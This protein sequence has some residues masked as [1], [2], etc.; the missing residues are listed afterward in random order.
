M[1]PICL[2]ILK[3]IVEPD[4]FSLTKGCWLLKKLNNAVTV[5]K[6]AHQSLVTLFQKPNPFD[7]G[8][9]YTASFLRA[10]WEVEK[11]AQGTKDVIAQD[12]R[13]ELARLISLEDDLR[14][15]W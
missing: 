10:Q 2:S 4:L 8:L 15:A 3:Q 7:S 6:E 14:E 13:L 1:S 12:H 5:F 11:K 9:C